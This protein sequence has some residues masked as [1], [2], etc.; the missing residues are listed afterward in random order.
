MGMLDAV[1][2]R[3]DKPGSVGKG[4]RLRLVVQPV[5]EVDPRAER[6]DDI[7]KRA[8]LSSLVDGNEVRVIQYGGGPCFLLEPLAQFGRIDDVACAAP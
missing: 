3:A 6:G 2:E 5:G 7:A 1:S 8:D 4:D